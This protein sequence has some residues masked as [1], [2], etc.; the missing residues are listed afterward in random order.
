MEYF[1]NNKLIPPAAIGTWAWGS[2][3][4]GSK[5]I[6]GSSTEESV[7][8]EAFDIAFENGYTLWDTAAIY[9]MGT[10]ESI[11]A[12]A[13]KGKEIILST[14]YTPTGRF[15]PKAIDAML[16]ASVERM[17]GQIPDVYWLHSPSNIEKNLTHFC[18]LQ[19]A[20][21]IH[22][23]GVSNFNLEQVEKAAE[24]L[25]K[26]GFKLGGVQNHYSLVYR[27]SERAGVLNWC[28]E[29]G[30]PFFAYMVL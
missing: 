4:N 30:V 22:S 29:N 7:L 12:R 21:K 10:A 15:N 9:G 24:I 23:I 28:I 17:G 2:G 20:G 18:E 11:L 1:V 27:N 19:K 3:A 13:C 26:Y 5:M 8:K 25:K 14:K 16:K 6:F